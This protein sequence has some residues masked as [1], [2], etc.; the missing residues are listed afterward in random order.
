VDSGQFCLAH[1][2][3]NLGNRAYFRISKPLSCQVRA[4]MRDGRKAVETTVGTWEDAGPGSKLMVRGLKIELGRL[5][6]GMSF[7]GFFC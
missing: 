7:N 1:C 4:E 3:R 6:V 5:L 2:R